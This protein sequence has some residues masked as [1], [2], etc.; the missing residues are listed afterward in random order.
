MQGWRKGF[1]RV[2]FRIWEKNEGERCPGEWCPVN[3]D[4]RSITAAAKKPTRETTDA[5]TQKIAQRIWILSVQRLITT[6][7]FCHMQIILN[8]PIRAVQLGSMWPVSSSPT[9]TA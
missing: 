7:G 4:V 6:P 2:I 8:L 9:D 5:R 1:V 3:F